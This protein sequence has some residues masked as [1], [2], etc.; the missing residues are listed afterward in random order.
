MSDPITSD[1]AILG[2]ATLTVE[3][4]I[5]LCTEADLPALE[6]MGLYRPH[7]SII[8]ATFKAQQR[9]DALMLL[10]LTGGFPVGQVWVDLERGQ[11]GKKTGQATGRKTAYLWAVRSFHPLHGVGIGR[12]L[13]IT[14]EQLLKER[15]ITHAELCVEQDNDN[16]QRFYEKLGWRFVVAH[17]AKVEEGPGLWL[18][19]KDLR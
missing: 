19:A 16:A 5:R 11:T 18:M 8:R 9:G 2:R 17:G 6:W 1:P 14:A 3:M 7:R 12:H 10:G 4:V 13:M 15:G